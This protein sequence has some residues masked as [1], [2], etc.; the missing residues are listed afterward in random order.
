[1]VLYDVLSEEIMQKYDFMMDVCRRCISA[2][3]EIVFSDKKYDL[4]KELIDYI[5][6]L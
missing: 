4:P 3:E 2:C 6:S 5:K 1:M